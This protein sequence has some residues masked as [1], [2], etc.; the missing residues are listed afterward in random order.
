MPNAE[1]NDGMAEKQALAVK[2]MFNEKHPVH[3]EALHLLWKILP[4]I[5]IPDSRFAETPAMAPAL[6]PGASLHAHCSAGTVRP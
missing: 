6:A 1:P 5:V 4:D 2:T 3:R